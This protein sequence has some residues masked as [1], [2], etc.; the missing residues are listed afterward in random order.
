MM[1]SEKLTARTSSRW[2][3]L[4][5]TVG[6]AVAMSLSM[7]LAGDA[8]AKKKKKKKGTN[9][10]T[11]TF[12][13]G[14]VSIPSGTSE[15]L[16]AN[17]Y[18]SQA[19]VNI[20]KLM[21]GVQDLNVKIDGFSHTHPEDAD[22]M[23]A[24]PGGQCVILMSEVGG[25][26][27]ANNLNFTFDDQAANSL[28]NSGPLTSGTFK[29][30]NIISGGTDPFPAPAPDPATCSSSLSVFNNTN[31]NGVYKLFVIDEYGPQDGGSISNWSLEVTAKVKK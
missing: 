9:T 13:G 4:A 8:Q 5:L 14:G 21:G 18:P 28:P 31:P 20:N 2:M 26:T 25:S 24:A 17:P 12:S 11:Q 27:D 19:N 1:F 29:P 23:L 16:K 10:V 30:T 7:T 22:V 6:L 3:V 15:I